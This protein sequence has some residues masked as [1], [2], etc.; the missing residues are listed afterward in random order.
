MAQ[1]IAL[2][3]EERMGAYLVH[4]LREQ[5]DLNGNSWVDVDD[6]CTA[7]GQVCGDT[8]EEKIYNVVRNGIKTNVLYFDQ[9]NGR[10]GLMEYRELEQELANEIVRIQ[11]AKQ[12]LKLIKITQKKS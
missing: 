11:K 8:D 12:P 2:D 3:S 1:G 4:Y 7:I 10:V 9:D 5:A 6:L